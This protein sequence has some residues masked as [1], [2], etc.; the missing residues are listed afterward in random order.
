M[1]EAG[2]IGVVQSRYGAFRRLLLPIYGLD[3]LV[4]VA[5]AALP[6]AWLA[7]IDA[8]FALYAGVG[9]YVGF[10]LTMQRSTPSVLWLSAKDEKRVTEIL[11]RSTYFERTTDGHGWNSTKG[12]LNHWDTDNLRLR[13]SRDTIQL[14]GRQIDLR[15]IVSILGS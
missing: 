2:E 8:T 14:T 1:G 6:F 9:A 11:D 10:V 13:R 3:Q 5:I 7:T 15:Q 12:R 4:F